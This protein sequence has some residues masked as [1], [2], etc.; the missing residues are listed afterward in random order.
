MQ[1]LL[2]W[3]YRL[4]DEDERAALRRL[5]VFGGGFSLAAATAAVAAAD[6]A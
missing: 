2:D 3:S 5:S 1:A 4:L 6:D